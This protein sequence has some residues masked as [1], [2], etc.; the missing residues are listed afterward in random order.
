M[1][2][3]YI[4]HFLSLT[5]FL[6]LLFFPDLSLFELFIVPC[7]L[8]LFFFVFFFVGCF[9]CGFRAR[10]LISVI[11]AC[12]HGTRTRIS[13][14]IRGNNK[15]VIWM[16]WMATVV[17]ISEKKEAHTSTKLEDNGRVVEYPIQD[18]F[19]TSDLRSRVLVHEQHTK[20][21][22]VRA[23]ENTIASYGVIR[24]V[25]AVTGHDT[26]GGHESSGAPSQQK[27]HA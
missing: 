1:C 24:E 15:H 25:E 5:L 18:D 16:Y 12:N 2:F 8:S 22:T 9:L 11:A 10:E 27:Q 6:G 19:E 17:S 26:E 21:T 20:T 7:F 23:S 14:L 3:L 4:P 13:L